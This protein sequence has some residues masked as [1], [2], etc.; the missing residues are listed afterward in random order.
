MIE[1]LKRFFVEYKS[2]GTDEP[3]KFHIRDR[4]NPNYIDLAPTTKFSTKQ[5]TVDACNEYDDQENQPD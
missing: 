3:G 4:E 1:K 2:T 5:G